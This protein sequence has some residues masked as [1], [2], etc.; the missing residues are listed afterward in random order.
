MNIRNR[1]EENSIPLEYLK[2]LHDLHEDWL[3][4]KKY[5]LAAPVVVI[6]A[7]QVTSTVKSEKTCQ[8]HPRTCHRCKQS[9]GNT[10]PAYS[11]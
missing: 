7:D 2:D 10:S 1:S 4:K 8:P 3:I 6:D 11:V 9:T 5:P